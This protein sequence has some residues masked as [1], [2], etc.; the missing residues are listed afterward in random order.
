M[1]DDVLEERQSDT[2]FISMKDNNASNINI[3][4]HQLL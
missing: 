1:I 3:I 4:I 2:C